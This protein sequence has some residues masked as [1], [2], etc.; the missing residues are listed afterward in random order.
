MRRP[1]R[2]G[3]LHGQEGRIQE[4]ADFTP[5]FWTTTPTALQRGTTWATPTS[6]GRYKEAGRHDFAIAIEDSSRLPIIKSRGFD[7]HAAV[8][9]C[10][11]STVRPSCS[12]HPNPARFATWQPRALGRPR[13]SRTVLHAVPR[14]DAHFWRRV[15][16]ACWT[17]C[18]KA[19]YPPWS[20]FYLFLLLH[21]TTKTPC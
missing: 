8:W 6:V 21:L 20:T 14:I 19:T 15:G 18:V 2:V 13:R 11:T 7:R 17:T 10:L 9:R 5:N 16:L 12:M 1:S 4:A 3:I